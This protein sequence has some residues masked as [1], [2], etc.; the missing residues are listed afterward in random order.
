MNF[1][2][3]WCATRAPGDC[4]CNATSRRS[5][6]GSY[7]CSFS[8]R[9]KSQRRQQLK[10]RVQARS[11]NTGLP[12]SDRRF[13]SI[14][15]KVAGYVSSF[16]EGDLLGR[17]PRVSLEAAQMATTTMTFDDSRAREEIGYTSRPAAQALFDS[18]QWFVEN[19]YVNAERVR[20]ITWN[21]PANQ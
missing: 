14:F 2:R 10:Q 8:N 1:R 4:C 9:S 5:S 18:A 6:T 19:G 20:M 7:R 15:P 21:P 16:V 13:P 12:P 11:H 3:V 17:E